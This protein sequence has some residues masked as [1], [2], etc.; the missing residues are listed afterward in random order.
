VRDLA[1]QESGSVLA[2][3]P[4]H[5]QEW[6]QGRMDV[7][8]GFVHGYLVANVTGSQGA[9]IRDLFDNCRRT[10]S[11]AIAADLPALPRW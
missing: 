11:I 5:A 1:L 4:Q 6:Q 2:V 9:R 10:G 8:G 3:D 7:L